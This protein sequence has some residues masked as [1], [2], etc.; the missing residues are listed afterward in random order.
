M[1]RIP[2]EISNIPAIVAEPINV[3]IRFPHPDPN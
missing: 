2:R 3:G 1:G